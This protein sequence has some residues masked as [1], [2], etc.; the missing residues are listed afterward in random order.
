MED[1]MKAKISLCA[2]F[3]VLAPFLLAHEEFKDLTL[4][5]AGINNL[6]INCGAG[7]CKVYGQKGLNKINVEAEIVIKGL[8]Q[9]KAKKY[10]EEEA[11][12]WISQTSGAK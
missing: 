1:G 10:I 4:D 5:S 7:F 3:L 2:L 11:G 12:T 6:D 9:E 8:S